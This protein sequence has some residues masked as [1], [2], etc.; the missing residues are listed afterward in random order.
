MNPSAEIGPQENLAFEGLSFAADGS[1]LWLAMEGPL[2]QDGENATAEQGATVRFTNIDRSGNV[3]GQYAYPIDPIP[4]VP[5]G[6]GLNGVTE[7]L[8]IDQ[9]RILVI[10][11]ASSEDENGI[12][13]NFIKIYEAD[14]RGATNV[15]DVASLAGA[16]FTPISKRLVLDL[17]AAGVD[18]IDNIEGITWGPPLANGNRTLL[19][20][21]D[22]NFNETLVTEF[23]ALEV[24]P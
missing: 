2:Y 12:Y 24:L 17:N 15:Q 6:F 23:I 9:D 4:V 21:S 11:R 1:S 3:L 16:D 13:T 18:P 10:E 22:D 5:A 20:V 19:L 8:A 7:I 14:V